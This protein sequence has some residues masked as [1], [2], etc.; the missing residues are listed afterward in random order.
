MTSAD[1]SL[2]TLYQ[3]ME[4]VQ[5]AGEGE[6]VSVQDMLDAV[7]TRSFGPVLLVPAMIILSPI[8]GIPTVPTV[9]AVII[10]LIALQ[11]LCGRR[12]IWLPRWLLNLSLRRTT[13][14]RAAR[15][16]S[17]LARAVDRL[18]KPRLSFFV[19]RPFSQVIALL[20]ILAA[21]TMPVLE[22]L[23]FMASTAAAVICV[24]ALALVAH[25]GLL[26]LIALLLT[27]GLA[28]L[29]VTSVGG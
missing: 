14:D 4:R 23:P 10:C 1:D 17:P 26:V 9:G 27:G 15:F 16:I 8:S 3:V 13:L 7:G 12:S 29:G 19:R 6:S 5:S 18:L 2:S 28:L 11:L 21:A 24:Y 25:D 22:P 20:C